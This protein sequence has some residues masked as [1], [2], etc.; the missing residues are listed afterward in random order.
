[1]H[2][3]VGLPRL[4]AAYATS[5]GVITLAVLVIDLVHFG[6][7]PAGYW[8]WTGEIWGAISK[9]MFVAASLFTLGETALF[10]WA[11]RR[12]PVR[13]WIP[14]I[15]GRWSGDLESNWA[16]VSARLKGDYPVAGQPTQLVPVSVV[17]KARLLSV[18][19]RLEADSRY[20]NSDTIAVSVSCHGAAGTLRLAYVYENH[21]PNPEQTD[22][23]HHFGAGY[24][25]LLDRG[26]TQ[27]FEGNYWTNRNWT[28][29][30]NTAGRIVLRRKME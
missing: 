18:N 13:L 25:D 28:K 16:Q 4:L 10:P 9:G 24:V 22:S 27:S 6:R 7:V 19:M 23:G 1:M 20:S 11:C 8:G 12:W 2:A 15:D 14:D 17:I 3:L 26:D 30:L 5:A 29:G 21:T